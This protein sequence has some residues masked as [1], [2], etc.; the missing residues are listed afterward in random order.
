MKWAGV[1]VVV[2]VQPAAMCTG[3]MPDAHA[4]AH[5]G[6]MSL[7][8]TCKAGTAVTHQHEVHAGPACGRRHAHDDDRLDCSTLA[9]MHGHSAY[10]PVFGAPIENGL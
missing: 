6:A 1:L 9:T 5:T 2:S 7:Q 10:A 3:Q 8:L 4:A